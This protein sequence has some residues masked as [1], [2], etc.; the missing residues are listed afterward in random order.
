MIK[1]FLVGACKGV[2]VVI[3]IKAFG[4]ETAIDGAAT[5]MIVLGIADSIEILYNGANNG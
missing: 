3:A 4:I 1:A 2:L 5:A